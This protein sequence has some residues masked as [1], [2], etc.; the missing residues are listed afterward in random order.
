[1]QYRLQEVGP[2][3]GLQIWV[4]RH[5]QKELDQGN[6]APDMPLGET[7]E[8]NSAHPIRCLT[9]ENKA[10]RGTKYTGELP[11]EWSQD[12]PPTRLPKRP[13]SGKK[14]RGPNPP[15]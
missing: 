15:P 5:C 4:T 1:M 8:L 14:S 13:P 9:P 11:P 3:G 7:L 10:H 2:K 12:L 6:S